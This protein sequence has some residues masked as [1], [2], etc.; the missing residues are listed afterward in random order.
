MALLNTIQNTHQTYIY[1]KKP[2]FINTSIKAQIRIL[3]KPTTKTNKAHIALTKKPNKI[4]SHHQLKPL[5]TPNNTTKKQKN[6]ITLGIPRNNK[7]TKK[8][9]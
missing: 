8:P 3:T 4:K 6:V 1:H 7:H 9:K 5:I 2:V